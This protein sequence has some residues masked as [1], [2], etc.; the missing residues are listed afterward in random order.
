[1]VYPFIVYPLLFVGLYFQV[2]LLYTFIEFLLREEEGGNDLQELPDKDLPSVT[3]MVPC[4]NE[5]TTVAG[6][7]DSLLHLDYPQDKLQIVVINDGSTDNTAEVLA[8]YTHHKQILI[9]HKENEG[10]KYHALNRGLEYAQTDVV[11]CL[12]A[13]SFVEKQTLREMIKIFNIPHTDAVIPTLLIH[14]PVNVLQTMQKV[15]FEMGLF[16]KKMFD[17]MDGL[18]IAPGPF[19][20]FRR[21]VFRELGNYKHAH[22]TEDCEIALRMQ[23]HHKRIRHAEKGIVYTVGVPKFKPLFR[24][25]VRWVYGGIR[26]KIDYRELMFNK[27]YGDLGMFVLPFSLISQYLVSAALVGLVISTGFN[28][29]TRIIQIIEAGTFSFSL[30]SFGGN[31]FT[32]LNLILLVIVFGSIYMGRVMIGKEQ[33]ITF[34]MFYGIVLLGFISPLWVGMSVYNSFRSHEQSWY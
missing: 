34:D 32:W 26:N 3:I 23:K 2:F 29:V 7:L 9:I 28:L 16:F 19:S 25:R 30:F 14:D 5:E 22:N 15:E 4:Y 1:M 10:S 33:K 18:Y 21:D 13:D 17:E 8:T 11:G 20:L 31:A 24:Q 12:D 27:E 6:T